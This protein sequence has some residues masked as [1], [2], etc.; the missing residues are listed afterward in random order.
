MKRPVQNLVERGFRPGILLSTN[1]SALRSRGVQE[2][3]LQSTAEQTRRDSL[4]R[5]LR[6]LSL[7]LRAVPPALSSLLFVSTFNLVCDPLN[8]AIVSLTS[9]QGC[10]PEPCAASS[11][12]R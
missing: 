12:V 8:L 7:R 10:T 3:T 4:V 9:Q 1:E 11:L 2:R 5:Y 6:G